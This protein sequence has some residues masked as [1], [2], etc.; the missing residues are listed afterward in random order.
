[1]SLAEAKEKIGE[2][3][4]FI[5]QYKVAIAAASEKFK[6][7]I[8]DKSIPLEDR[9]GLF[10]KAPDYLI[11]HDFWTAGLKTLDESDNGHFSYY[12]NWYVERHETV[13]VIDKVSDLE[14]DLKY[15]KENPGTAVHIKKW[16][17]FFYE[18][19]SK[20]D[21]LKE[22]ILEKNLGSFEYDW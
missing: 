20:L 7:T 14:S 5:E 6:A 21:E 11:D 15:F 8:K 4:E 10:L 22:E 13:H 9:W 3:E 19:P 17:M 18:N 16:K 1:M 2:V 12:D